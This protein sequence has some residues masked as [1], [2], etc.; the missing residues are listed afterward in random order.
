MTKDYTCNPLPNHIQKYAFDFRW[1]NEKIWALNIPTEKMSIDELV[2]HF[3]VA[4]LHTPGERFN[5]TP[6]K[7]MQNPDIYPEQY[8]RTLE[9]DLSYP[10]DVMFHKDRWLILDGLHRLMKSVSQ[11]RTQVRVHKIPHS[12]IPMISEVSQA[13]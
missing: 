4:W 3:D 13:P 6:A 11:G 5:L 9:S 1:D 2:W 8:R 7:I 12:M 10:I